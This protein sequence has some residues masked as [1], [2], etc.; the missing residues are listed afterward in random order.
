MSNTY[1]YAVEL[2]SLNFIYGQWFTQME[3]DFNWPVLVV[4]FW[5]T[6]AN[7][8]WPF[9]CPCWTQRGQG[10]RSFMEVAYTAVTCSEASA[11]KFEVCITSSLLLIQT[12]LE[13][14]SCS[15]VAHSKIEYIF[16]NFSPICT[17]ILNQ[18]CL[19]SK[20]ILQLPPTAA[21]RSETWHKGA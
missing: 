10:F 8:L 15:S 3:V 13:S 1:T 14:P 9:L 11:L 19:K 5:Q 6:V 21:Q 12:L 2:I 16:I 20:V 18:R 17:A 7:T 4:C